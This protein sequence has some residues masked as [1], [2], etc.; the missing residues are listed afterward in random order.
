MSDGLG[1]TQSFTI[2]VGTNAY[3]PPNPWV[4]P[5]NGTDTITTADNT[6]VTFTPQGESATAAG[7]AAPQVDVQLYRPVPGVANAYVDNSYVPTI[8]GSF[9]LEVGT[10][11]GRD[12]RDLFQQRESDHHGSQH[13][14]RAAGAQ[15][16]V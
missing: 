3:D 14:E 2:N 12:E 5:I 15:L 9:E 6:A 7:S 10:I 16:P 4:K 11:Y 8:S 13:P 1:G